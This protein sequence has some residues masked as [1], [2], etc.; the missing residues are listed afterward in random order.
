MTA[1]LASPIDVLH[2]AANGE[3]FD[4]ACA[5]ADVEAAAR[6]ARVY[7]YHVRPR[8]VQKTLEPLLGHLC[9]LRDRL[10]TL[11]GESWLD[12]RDWCWAASDDSSKANQ[13]VSDLHE[14][15]AM[16]TKLEP[17]LRDVVDAMYATHGKEGRPSNDTR[18]RLFH[19]LRAIYEKHT[20]RKATATVDES[21]LG[22]R[23]YFVSFVEA[24]YREMELSIP[25][26]LGTA[27]R[28]F[29]YPNKSKGSQRV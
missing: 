25:A 2:A 23:G 5:R 14:L 24:V 26:G 12:L 7:D 15:R 11:N 9:K 13:I 27:L 3:M 6:R 21:E 17:R 10:N 8:E 16:V 20:P 28:N 22:A 4:D 1:K 29:L 18:N 19:D